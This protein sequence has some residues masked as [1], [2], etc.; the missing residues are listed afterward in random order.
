MLPVYAAFIQRTL[1]CLH[2]FGGLLRALGCH[3]RVR[4]F[5]FFV[6]EILL[7]DRYD[8]IESQGKHALFAWAQMFQPGIHDIVCRG[9]VL[10]YCEHGS[11][12]PR[13]AGVLKVCYP[14]SMN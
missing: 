14:A 5:V 4:S 6:V 9:Q 7:T 2:Q 10:S 12:E 3:F 11:Q 13:N 8:P 1:E